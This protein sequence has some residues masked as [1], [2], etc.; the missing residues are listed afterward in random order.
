MLKFKIDGKAIAKQSVRFT[1]SG[2]KYTP[3]HIKDYADYVKLCFKQAYPE[4]MP[5]MLE[6]VPLE[7]DIVVAFE[8]PKSFS[9]SKRL[10]ALQGDLKPL[11]KPDVDNI[12]KNILDSLNSLTYPDDK[13]V[14]RLNIQKIYS[15]FAHVVVQIKKGEKNDTNSKNN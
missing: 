12:S 3:K 10:Q 9:K 5:E 13:Q 7:V 8:I 2:H 4:H 1:R 6:D 11:T 14:T 15:A